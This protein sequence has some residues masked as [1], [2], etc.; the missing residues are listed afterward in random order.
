[1]EHLEYSLNALNDVMAQKLKSLVSV[2]SAKDIKE[3]NNFLRESQKL[4][5]TLYSIGDLSEEYVEEGGEAFIESDGEVDYLGILIQACNYI[6]GF[7]SVVDFEKIKS[8]N[9]EWLL[10]ESAD[11]LVEL[12]H[13]FGKRVPA[14]PGSI[15]SRDGAEC[16]AESES[17]AEKVK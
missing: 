10:D 8:A 1:M 13:L 15:E 9:S 4:K 2:S 3:I 14:L 5:K 6:I 17:P 12:R 11:F 16:Q 7:H